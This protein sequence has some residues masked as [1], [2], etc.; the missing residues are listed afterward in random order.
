[1]IDANEATCNIINVYVKVNLQPLGQSW[2]TWKLRSM[3]FAYWQLIQ[4]QRPSWLIIM[5]R[6]KKGWYTWP[7]LASTLS[8]SKVEMVKGLA[9][10]WL[11]SFSPNG[12]NALVWGGLIWGQMSLRCL[13]TTLANEW[14]TMKSKQVQ[15]NK[16]KYLEHILCHMNEYSWNIFM[17]CGIFWW[18][19]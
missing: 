15:D 2:T 16:K 18:C 8:L 10:M 11:M 3:P 1:M 4:V 17:Q 6:S 13:V 14:Q 7:S 9:I 5:G 12:G 19:V